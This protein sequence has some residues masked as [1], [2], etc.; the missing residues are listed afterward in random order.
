M[1]I[2]QGYFIIARQILQSEVM[3][4]NPVWFKLW[5]WLLAKANHKEVKIKGVIFHRGEVLTSYAEM[6]E[7]CQ[8]KIGYRL[9]KPSKS[10][11][12]NFCEKLTKLRMA[13]TTKTTRGFWIKIDKYDFFQN[14]NNYEEN[15]EGNNK[16]TTRQQSR[17]TVNK[18][19][20]NDNNKKIKKIN[21]KN[22][23]N[24]DNQKIWDSLSKQDKWLV[25]K[26]H[27]VIKNG[28]L[29]SVDLGDI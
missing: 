14:P 24:S 10:V 16:T 5:I 21:K 15:N 22:K 13:T 9:K 18:N 7:V 3:N 17:P 1:A 8:Y 6:Q 19:D 25:E 28:R 26:G 12:R 4:W 27:L 20:K 23:K 11:I 2:E 29:L